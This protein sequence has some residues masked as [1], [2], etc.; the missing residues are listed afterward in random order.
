MKHFSVFPVTV[1]TQECKICNSVL[2]HVEW[3][4]K[5]EQSMHIRVQSTIKEGLQVP[6]KM[7]VLNM[8]WFHH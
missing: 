5:H 3:A 6:I 2:L 8:V 4:S 1:S 7:N